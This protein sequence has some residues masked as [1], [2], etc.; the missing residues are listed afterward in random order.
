[1]PSTYSPDLRI[2]LIANGEQSGTWGTT[3]NTNLGTLIE[4]AISGSATV[5]IDLEDQALTAANG[6]ADEA[7]C[8]ALVFSTGSWADA[9]NVFAPPVTKLYVI[10]N[11]TPYN[12]DIWCSTVIGNTTPA[13]IGYTIP[14]GKTAFVR[15]DGMEFHDAV[16]YISGSVSFTNASL[17]T[18]SLSGETF[19]TAASVTAGTDLQGQGALTADY[20]VIAVASA[21]PS[22]VT[23]PATTTGRRIIIVNKGANPINVYPAAG[24]GIDALATNASVQIP[25]DGVLEFNAASTT[26]WYSFS[27]LTLTSPLITTPSLVAAKVS[28]TANVTA[29]SSS[30]GQGPLTSDYNVITSAASNPSG[31]TLPTATTGRKVLIVNKGANSVNVFPASGAAIDAL[32][33]NASISL[34]TNGV[35]EFNASSSTQWYSSFNATTAAS[36]SGVSFT[37]TAPAAAGQVTVYDS[38]T[39]AV[40]TTTRTYQFRA[41]SAGQ[42]QIQLFEDTDNGTNSVSIQ[43]PASLAGSYTL[44]LPADDGTAGQ[45]L[46]TDGSGTLSWVSGSGTITSV[47]AGSGMSFTTATSGGV[48]VTMGTPSAITSSS[49]NS[50]SSGTHT[51]EITGAAFLAGSQTFTG[52]KRFLTSGVGG[53]ISEAYNFTTTNES[54]YGSS[55][56]VGISTG[57]T[58]RVVTT[59]SAFRPTGDNNY[60]L[61]AAG[62]RWSIVYAGTGTINTSD[63]DTK[64]DIADLDA[65]EKRVAVSIKSLIKKFRFK[66]AVEAKGA[67]ARIHV[68]VIAQEVRD[69][70]TA[71]GLDANRYGLFCS[72]TWWEKEVEEPYLPTGEIRTVTKLYATQ[73]EGATEVTRLG[74]RYDE[75]LAFVIAAM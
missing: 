22:G 54:I 49:T 25:V 66:D 51:H 3:T 10:K 50:A 4:D 52:I 33:P 26:R 18:P 45:V 46:S 19:S 16:D 8:A 9:F 13:G 28:T 62:N 12:A 5:T 58:G 6:A 59:N 31:V 17:T 44:T 35:L 15:S 20:N 40:L 14:A 42:A 43:S 47:A 74:V 61:G 75:L 32:A 29:G 65:A 30:Q 72:D 36:T 39:G 2:E 69:A 48:T 1:M 63:A 55:G 56:E 27:S 67:A 38:T 70:F 73:V 57:G 23:L 41:T 53:I 11:D 37:G 7:R 34:P 24:S 64:Q 21:N 71:E 60:T 68:G